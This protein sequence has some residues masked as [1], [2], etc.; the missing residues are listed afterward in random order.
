MSD[1]MTQGQ[2]AK[3]GSKQPVMLRPFIAGSRQTDEPDYDVSQ[4]LGASEV[5][6]PS[7]QISPSGYLRGIHLLVECTAV[8]TT[9][10][11]TAFQADGPFNVLSNVS[12][13]DTNNQPVVGPLDGYDL[14]VLNKY[15]GYAFQDDAKNSPVYST[16][17]GTVATGG[18]FTFVLY[19]PVE[20]VP[21]DALGAQPNKSGA[22]QFSLTLS[23][24]TLAN[25]YSDDPTT[26][27]T[28]RVRA[29]LASWQDP[30]S[31]DS[32]GNPT[33]QDPPAVQTSQYWSKQ[34]YSGLN[35]ATNTRLQGIDGLLRSLI[36]IARDE[37]GSRATG[38]TEWPD[39]FTVKYEN[40]LLFES[41]IR[42]LWRHW[43]ARNYGYSAAADA[44]N[45]RD[46]GVYPIWQ[47]MHDYAAKPGW[48]SRFS[49]LPMS[50]A[51][52]LEIQG[53]FGGQTNLTVLVNKIIPFPQGN[54]R[55]LTGGR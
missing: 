34:T 4:A 13:Q 48:E 29:T 5:R 23:L 31:N 41:R 16:T 47:W 9:A 26:S 28:V 6:L 11:T 54:I 44:A 27:A 25:V 7:Y 42:T 43:I 50:T 53:T 8:N 35:G 3:G 19:V 49:Y 20:I 32:R 2:D 37:N 51:S 21:R 36:F 55:G 45:G 46:S 39:P 15:G 12:F 22:S 18:S 52:N 14:Y 30:D 10:S 38:D 17:T 1:T 40:S 24:N 33:A